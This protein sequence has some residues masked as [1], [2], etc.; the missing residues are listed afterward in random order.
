M[1]VCVCVCVHNGWTNFCSSTNEPDF[2]ILCSICDRCVRIGLD[3]L[4]VNPIVIVLCT[5][6]VAT[7]S[8]VVVTLIQCRWRA[9][10]RRFVH[11]TLSPWRHQH[12]EHCQLTARSLHL[13]LSFI[14]C[15]FP[16]TSHIVHIIYKY[17]VLFG[18]Y[19]RYRSSFTSIYAFKS[20][21]ERRREGSPNRIK[22]DQ[23][24]QDSNHWMC[25]ALFNHS[26]WFRFLI[27]LALSLLDRVRSWYYSPD[28]GGHHHHLSMIQF[29]RLYLAIPNRLRVRVSVVIRQFLSDIDRLLNLNENGQYVNV[30]VCA[31]LKMDRSRDERTDLLL[32]YIV[33]ME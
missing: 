5:Q 23:N 13:I 32:L 9:Y 17:T 18:A 11:Y 12:V 31:T 15:Y 25:R 30:W 10:C 19:G 27:N 16:T 21:F 24:D 26:C 29:N 2:I 20:R 8:F 3:F 33:I 7:I 22:L 4:I 28:G 1:W 6:L 14:H